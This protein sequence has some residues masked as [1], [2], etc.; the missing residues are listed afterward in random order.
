MGFVELYQ[1]DKLKQYL[2][3]FPDN[4]KLNKIYDTIGVIDASFKVLT[5]ELFELFRYLYDLK[6]CS[7]KNKEFYKLLPNEYTIVLYKIRGIYYDI[8]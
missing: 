3:Y 1:Q 4:M 7:H 2:E 8:S 6:D 5:S